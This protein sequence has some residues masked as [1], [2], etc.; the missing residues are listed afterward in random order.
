[1][2]VELKW[3]PSDRRIRRQ[4]IA[5]DGLC[6]LPWLGDEEQVSIVVRSA[7]GRS[8]TTV[9]RAGNDGR[10][11]DLSLVRELPLSTPAPEKAPA[12]AAAARRGR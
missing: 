9:Q 1:M 10:V 8:E 11:I 2:V 5:S 7:S 6:M 3:L 12:S 4:V